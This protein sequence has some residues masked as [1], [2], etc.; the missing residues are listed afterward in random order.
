M[1]AKIAD[2]VLEELRQGR[3][4]EEIRTKFRS[5]SQIYEGLRTFMEQSEKL[6]EETNAAIRETAEQLS[7]KRA[8]LKNIMVGKPG[9]DG[10]VKAP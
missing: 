8:E 1:I 10:E 3:N 9:R 7:E 6:A 2:E 5:S 4:L